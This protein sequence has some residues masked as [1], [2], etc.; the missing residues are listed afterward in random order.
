MKIIPK[1]TRLA[2]T[3]KWKDS[4]EVHLGDTLTVFENNQLPYLFS[5]GEYIKENYSGIEHTGYV[6]SIQHYINHVGPA[7][8]WQHN[9]II[10]MRDSSRSGEP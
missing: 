8:Q 1:Y 3:F 4:N 10:N 5:V 9:L 6:K 2:I 7:D